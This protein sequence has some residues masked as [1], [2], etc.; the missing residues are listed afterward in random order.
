MCVAL[1]FDWCNCRLVGFETLFKILMH[2]LNFMLSFCETNSVFE[3]VGTAI[4][5]VCGVDETLVTCIC[6]ILF[7]AKS[8]SET[9]EWLAVFQK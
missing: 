3:H 9:L 8:F 1:L 7:M 4:L 6:F 5:V 2:S